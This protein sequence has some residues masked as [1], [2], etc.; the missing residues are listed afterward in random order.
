M[1]IFEKG[2]LKNFFTST[3]TAK[4]FKIPSNKAAGH[5]AMRSPVMATGNLNR[6]DILKELGTGLYLS[7]LHYLNWSDRESARITGMTRYACFWVENG[8]IIAPIKDLR[9]DESIYHFFGDGLLAVTDF[10]EI[11]PDTGSYNE[12]QVGGLKVPG[13]LVKNFKFTL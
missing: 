1:P 8:K 3:R 2:E 5:E 11:I 12:R 4:E 9:F 6:E 7:N 13:M 10:S